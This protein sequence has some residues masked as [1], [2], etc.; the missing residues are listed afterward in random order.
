MFKELRSWFICK[1][2]Q[3]RM[4]WLYFPIVI[5]MNDWDNECITEMLEFQLRVL[6]KSLIEMNNY[7][8]YYDFTDKLAEMDIVLEAIHR[9][10]VDGQ[11][12]CNFDEDRY[13]VFESLKKYLSCWWI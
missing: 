4:L 5:T 11:D 3:L 9:I 2:N 8:R 10:N 12:Y 6:Q 1:S 7:S 13:I